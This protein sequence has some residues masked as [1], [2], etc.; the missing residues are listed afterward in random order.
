MW[1]LINLIKIRKKTVVIITPKRSKY[2]V[3]LRKT[4]KDPQCIYII[5]SLIDGWYNL[6]N[7]M[8]GVI[9]NLVI[10]YY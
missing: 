2:S 6:L 3:S 4:G 5:T 1:A 9:V 8:K 7:C 10:N